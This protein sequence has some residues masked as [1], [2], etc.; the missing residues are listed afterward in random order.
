MSLL[1]LNAAIK[2]VPAAI[3]VSKKKK[4]RRKETTKKFEIG[5]DKMGHSKGKK[6]DFLCT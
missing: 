5:S 4:Q 6:N 1:G 2:C 3:K